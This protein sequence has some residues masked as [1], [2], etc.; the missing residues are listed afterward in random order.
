MAVFNGTVMP[1]RNRAVIKG[2]G[3]AFKTGQAVADRRCKQILKAVASG[4]D[5]EKD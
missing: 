1:S 2:I 5:M 4:N 3:H